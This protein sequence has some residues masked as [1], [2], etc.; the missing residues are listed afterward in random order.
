MGF[1]LFGL[2][3]R[4]VSVPVLVAVGVVSIACGCTR[5]DVRRVAVTLRAPRERTT[6]THA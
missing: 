1:V 6:Y 2:M 5:S 4:P 3:R